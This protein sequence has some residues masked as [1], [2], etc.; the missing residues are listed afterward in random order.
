MDK[1]TV[2][3]DEYLAFYASTLNALVKKLN[4]ARRESSVTTAIEFILGRLVCA[5]QSIEVLRKHAAHKYAFDGVMILRG[6]YDTMLQAP[7][8][9]VRY[10]TTRIVRKAI[11]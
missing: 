3:D 7:L 2:T 8:Y 6:M 11:S 4:G 10:S 1:N 9:H 5:G